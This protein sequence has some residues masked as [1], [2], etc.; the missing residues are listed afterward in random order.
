MIDE[1]AFAF[2]APGTE[3]V[4]VLARPANPATEKGLALV[5]V[6]G[7]PQTRVGSHRQFVL[8]TRAAAAE[9]YPSLRFDYTGMGDSP[10]PKPDFE[11]AGQDIR[12][13]CDA[14]QERVPACR[15]FVLW[16]LCDGASAALL[17][18]AS[19]PRIVAVVA[20]N[21]WARSEA[22][23]SAVIVTDHYGSR[24]RSPEFWKKLATGKIDI[25]A[26][27]REA[28]G[29]FWRA[30]ASRTGPADGRA[31]GLPERLAQALTNRRAILRF[32]ISGRDLTAA[33]FELAMKSVGEAVY[34]PGAAL[35]LEQADH[36]FSDPQAW[37]A[38]IEDTKS[39]LAR[40]RAPD[41]PS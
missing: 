11:A 5:V 12:R 39:V 35:R 20:A 18:A 24:L 29:H 33:E 38:V 31:A 3:L 15:R 41:R 23:R 13:A 10:G 34:D 22:T 8:L 27:A 9:G 1:V 17:Y 40:P 21:P 37:Q 28:L 14:L 19:D 32:Q 25:V 36:T 7:G 2:G 6:V 16:G 26:S 4:G 30:R